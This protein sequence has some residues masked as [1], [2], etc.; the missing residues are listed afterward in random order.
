M[1]V[2][3]LLG[4]SVRMPVNDTVI[5]FYQDYS[6]RNFIV[7]NLALKCAVCFINKFCQDL[8]L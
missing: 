3:I 7:V 2:I 5:L 1:I 8:F 6:T 4:K